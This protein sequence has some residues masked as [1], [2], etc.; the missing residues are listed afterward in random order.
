MSRSFGVARV[1]SVWTTQMRDS[2]VME[3]VSAV[4]PMGASSAA[5]S[6]QRSSESPA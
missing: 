2:G 4:A 1:M 6:A 5:K 3:D